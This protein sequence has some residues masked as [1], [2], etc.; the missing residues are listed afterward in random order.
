[1]VALLTAGI[2]VML[3][4]AGVVSSGPVVRIIAGPL[5]VELAIDLEEMLDGP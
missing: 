3:G 2:D 4:R 1:M 5:V